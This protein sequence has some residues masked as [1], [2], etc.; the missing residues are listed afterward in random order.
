R[1][2][3]RSGRSGTAATARRPLQILQIGLRDP[4]PQPRPLTVIDLDQVELVVRLTEHLRLLV[5]EPEQ[6]SQDQL[7]GPTVADDQDRAR[8]IAREDRI[9]R[10]TPAGEVLVQRPARVAPVAGVPYP[11][12]A[13]APCHR[14]ARVPA[15]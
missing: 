11:R 15:P 12:G 9:E 8:A 5:R 14:T 1:A 4:L 2:R 7:V 3:R 10:R 6:C 13:L